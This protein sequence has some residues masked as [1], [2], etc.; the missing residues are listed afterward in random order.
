MRQRHSSK[1]NKQNLSENSKETFKNMTTGTASLLLNQPRRSASAT[2]DGTT[3]RA[4][5]YFLQSVF[6]GL[7][8][9]FEDV[10]LGNSPG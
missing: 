10:V 2:S 4:A 8:Q 7:S 9:G 6:S 3:S 5:K 1:A